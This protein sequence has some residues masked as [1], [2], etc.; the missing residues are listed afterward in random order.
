MSTA[1]AFSDPQSMTAAQVKRDLPA[2]AREHREN[3]A[4]AGDA[5][6]ALEFLR[7]LDALKT[8][9]ADRGATATV[10]AESRRTEVLIAHLA[11]SAKRGRPA[12]GKPYD[13][14]IA[15]LNDR[16]LHDFRSLAE[17]EDA[18]EELLAQG[19]VKRAAL[20]REI[21]ATPEPEYGYCPTCGHRL[22][23]DRPVRR[24]E[25]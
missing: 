13:V 17:H 1:I 3:I 12:N 21:G 15:E 22:R 23:K 20:L 10:E 8:Y 24:R 2:R 19:I 16:L 11:G 5:V 18:I 6:G 7:Q 4:E 25:A 9:L 14:R